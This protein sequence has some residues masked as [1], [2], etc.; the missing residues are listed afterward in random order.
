[1]KR[2]C[3]SDTLILVRTKLSNCTNVSCVLSWMGDHSKLQYTTTCTL[4]WLISV[5]EWLLYC[6][7]EILRHCFP[8]IFTPEKEA[9]CSSETSV[10]LTMYML[11]YPEDS[12]VDIFHTNSVCYIARVYQL[13]TSERDIFLGRHILPFSS[14]LS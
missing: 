2:V 9:A 5:C 10:I 3:S 8:V 13:L 7:K 1:M 12:T 14:K 4:F 6:C 11:V